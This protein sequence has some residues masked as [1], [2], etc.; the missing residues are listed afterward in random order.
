MASKTE[1]VPE[2]AWSVRMT[3]ALMARHS[4]LSDEWSH[5]Y[6]V[7]LKAVEEVWKRTKRNQYWEFIQRSIAPNVSEEGEIRGYALEEYSLDH[8]NSG[9]LLFPLYDRTGEARYRKAA[10]RL[11]DQFRTHPRTE[12]GGFWHKGIFER[13]MFLDGAYMGAPFY[14]EFAQR[15][16]EPEGFDDVAKQILLLAKHTRDEATGLH[17]H[18]W[19]ETKSQFWADPE[20]GRSPSFWSRAMGWYAMAIV[21][22]LDFLPAGHPQRSEIVAILRNLMAA[23]LKVRD[24]QTGVWNQIADRPATDGNYPEAS[25]SCMFVYAL[26]KGIRLGHLSGDFRNELKAAYAGILRQFV[27]QD[28]RGLPVLKGTCK[29]AGLGLDPRRDGSF[30]YYVSEPV[31]DNDFKGV[32][33]FILASV[34]MEQLEQPD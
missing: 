22:I 9:R 21:D 13:Q 3:E 6:G 28:E 11:R 33:A 1:T 7:V 27:G 10:F 31:A 30:A 19:D 24:P 20:T 14:A 34:E 2:H 5:E 4:D 29:T 26:A 12:E 18:G 16:G 8:I 15:F 25:A 17:V 32:G 23:V